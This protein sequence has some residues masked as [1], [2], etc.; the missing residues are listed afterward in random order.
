MQYANYAAD[1]LFNVLLAACAFFLVKSLLR[2]RMLKKLTGLRYSDISDESGKQIAQPLIYKVL[3]GLAIEAKYAF[4]R[5][6][7]ERRWNLREMAPELFESQFVA[8]TD[9]QASR[10]IQEKLKARN[11]FEAMHMTRLKEDHKNSQRRKATFWKAH[12]LFKWY[13]FTTQEHITDYYR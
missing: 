4:D 1:A 2:E 5:E 11:E 6:D 13:G 12:N 10:K 3:L 7:S 9:D 8:M